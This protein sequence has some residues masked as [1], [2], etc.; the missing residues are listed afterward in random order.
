MQLRPNA[1][2]PAVR[3]VPNHPTKEKTETG[4]TNVLPNP[5]AQ[6]RAWQANL[7]QGC[8]PQPAAGLDP[9]RKPK[10][11]HPPRDGYFNR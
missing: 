3:W 10:Y 8:R 9:L 1:G 7:Y 6:K 4:N 11:R 5:P 2:Y